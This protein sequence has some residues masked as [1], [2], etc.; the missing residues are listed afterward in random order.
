ML[1]HTHHETV[2]SREVMIPVSHV[3]LT[4]ELVIPADAVAVVIFL[5]RSGNER[6]SPGSRVVFGEL[7][8]CGIAALK[9][10]LL[11]PEENRYYES[12]FNLHLL[13]ERLMVVTAWV[14]SLPEL[15][16]FPVGYFGVDTEA[17]SAFMAAA[18]LKSEISA[19]VSQSGRPDL[20]NHR[21]Y[22]VQAPALLVAGSLDEQGVLLNEELY[23]HL[24]CEKK[25]A[26]VDGASHFFEEPG[27]AEEAVMLAVNWFRKYLVDG[28]LHM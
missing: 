26:I 16:E 14:Q 3:Y 6:C 5:Q 18:D 4:G 13:K 15:K 9:I 21:L 23:T 19:I 10:D 8:E 7:S 25:I 1:I 17:A 12:R 22:K 27:K 2:E 20:A 28:V 24:L 11:T